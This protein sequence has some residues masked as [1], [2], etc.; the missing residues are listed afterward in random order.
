MRY[1]HRRGV[2][3][4]QFLSG[5]CLMACLRLP[6][7][8]GDTEKTSALLD[9]T[10][11]PVTIA[12]LGDSVTG[13]Y[14][15]TGGK[16]AYPEMLE[17][18][19]RQAVPGARVTVINAGISGN[20]TQDGLARL[21]RDVL[22]H[23]P[24]LVTI[25]FGLNDMVRVSEDQF[26]RNL[27]TLVMRCRAAGCLVVLCTPNSV[28]TSGSRP[29]EKL[30]RYCD[31]IRAAGLDQKVPVCDQFKA[32][33]ELKAR[34]PWTWRLTLSDSIHPNMAGHR[35]M[36]EE[37]CRTITGRSTSL[38]DL[39]PAADPLARTTARIRSGQPVRVLA[40]SPFETQIETA[41]RQTYP[42]AVVEV[43]PWPVD[44]RTL[45]ELETAASQTVRM[46][47]PDLV[48]IAVPRSATAEP[49]EEFARSYSWVMN[50]SL[51]FGRADWDCVVIHPSVAAPADSSPRDALVRRLAAAQDL[52]LLD[53]A[54][55]D[56]SSSQ[57]ILSR[58]IESLAASPGKAN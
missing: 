24:D 34:D 14:Y 35:L 20:T 40:M 53:R 21:D 38:T 37:L 58:W 6:I 13:V 54:P 23:K 33:E 50:W 3:F 12:C 18:A 9:V 56:A 26:R 19:I 7:F 29:V 36:A 27:D 55:A 39:P 11:R 31:I 8:A 49:D 30:I 28:I 22:S 4:Q 48:V 57:V 52:H 5:I 16:R 15:H 17:V 42:D 32:G 47:K 44:G 43:T 46:M 10:A 1:L 41:L 2:V 45:R 51:S 25:S